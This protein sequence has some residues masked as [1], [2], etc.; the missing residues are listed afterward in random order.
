[1]SSTHSIPHCAEQVKVAADQAFI[2]SAA[3]TAP[4]DSFTRPAP[5]LVDDTHVSSPA[6]ISAMPCDTQTLQV[7]AADSAPELAGTQGASADGLINFDLASMI[8]ELQT[9]KDAKDASEEEAVRTAIAST[10]PSSVATPSTEVPAGVSSSAEASASQSLW[11]HPHTIALAS[12][13]VAKN[14]HSQP[15]TFHAMGTT[16]TSNEQGGTNGQNAQQATLQAQIQDSTR[17]VEFHAAKYQAAKQ[18]CGHFAAQAAAYAAKRQKLAQ[19][20]HLHKTLLEQ[21]CIQQAACHTVQRLFPTPSCPTPDKHLAGTNP[22]H[23][24]VQLQSPIVPA[25]ATNGP[26]V[27]I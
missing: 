12:P 14:S 13:L 18:G 17:E 24:T 21:L 19:D 5:L 3:H 6:P 16:S 1:M 7:I 26:K 11:I 4:V 22:I 10:R 8:Q 25:S 2:T 20:K 15:S 23:S 27:T 9:K